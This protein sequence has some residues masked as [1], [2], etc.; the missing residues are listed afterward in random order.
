VRDFFVHN[1]LYW[2]EEYHVDGLRFDAVHA[3]LDDS[4]PHIIQ[5]I[6]ERARTSLPGR[7]VHLILE[8]GANEARWLA[9]DE[10]QRPRLHTAQWNDDIHH[11]WHVVVTGEN[12]GYYA[13]YAGRELD[14]LGRCLTEGFAYQGEV[15][16]HEGKARGEPSS[17]LPPAAFVAF[18]QNHDQIGNRAFGERMS[19]LADESRLAIARAGLLLTPQIPMLYMGEEWSA[20]TPFLYFVDFSDDPDLA[21]AVRDG[22]RREFANFKSFAEQ[23][24]G[25]QIPDPTLEETFR[26]SVLDWA[27]AGRQPHA[28]VLADTRRLLALRQAEIVPLTKTRFIEASRSLPGPGQLACTWR[29]EGGTLRFLMNV[30]DAEAVLEAPGRPVWTSAGVKADGT[31]HHLPSWSATIVKE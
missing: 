22:R 5:E 14:L 26:L 13:D 21:E 7:E 12:D 4:T 10:A 24:G 9:R 2:L 11:C 27:E 25:R 29:Y 20:S 8:N 6:A 28:D 16:G 18:L 17:H 31:R 15:S 23:H 19:E 3:I 1:V 30:G